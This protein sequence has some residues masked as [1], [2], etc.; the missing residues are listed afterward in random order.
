M[1]TKILLAFVLFFVMFVIISCEDDNNRVQE[2][3]CARFTSVIKQMQIQNRASSNSTWEVGDEIGIY[4]LRNGYSFN[5]EEINKA[6]N[7]KCYKVTDVKGT[8][9]PE[10]NQEIYL[11]RDGSRYDFYAY[12]PYRED[13]SDFKLLVDLTQNQDEPVKND[14]L[15]SNNALNQTC[16]QPNVELTFTHQLAKISLTVVKS[17]DITDVD[18]SGM[19]VTLKDMPTKANFNLATGSWEDMDGVGAILNVC[20]VEAGNTFQ[21]IILPQKGG[22]YTN[23]MIVVEVPGKGIQTAEYIIADDMDFNAAYNYRY[24]ITVTKSVIEIAPTNTVEWDNTDDVTVGRVFYEYAIGDYYPNPVVDLSDPVEKAKVEGVVFS[25]GTDAGGDWIKIVGKTP[26]YKPSV[27]DKL[28]M[29]WTTT[30]NEQTEGASDEDNGFVNTEKVIASRA[31]SVPNFVNVYEAFSSYASFSMGWY[32]PSKNE[33]KEL[34]AGVCGLQYGIDIQ[35]WADRSEMVNEA[36]WGNVSDPNSYESKLQSFCAK[37]VAAGA[38]ANVLTSNYHWSS[39]E[40]GPDP[41]N[42]VW[43]VNLKKGVAHASKKCG[44]QNGNNLDPVSNTNLW[45]EQ[46][47]VLIKKVYI[48]Q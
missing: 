46:K 45:N 13:I 35:P 9:S 29:L 23:R 28:Y 36:T 5:A 26:V 47:A 20:P 48:N 38:P 11:P 44:T 14:L 15:F 22:V 31:A 4:M 8:L 21:T 32:L 10:I 40:Y 27:T 1:K 43:I 3:V 41:T 37:L 16:S 2:I 18:L 33:L 25:T 7:N 6:A 34:T 42:R 30:G 19:I 17:D 24:I 39:T 12:S